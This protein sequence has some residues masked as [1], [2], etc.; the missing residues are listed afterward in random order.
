VNSIAAGV[1]TSD[2]RITHCTFTGNGDDPNHIAHDRSELYIHAEGA[3]IDGNVFTGVRRAAP[4]AGAAIETHG[5]R[6]SITGNVITDYAGG[7]NLTGAAPS[8]S[9]GNVVSGN[10]IRGVL[11]G[12]GIWS[13][14]YSAHSSG[15]GINGLTITGN[16]I[17]VNQSSYTSSAWTATSSSGISVE[18]HS[19]LPLANVNISGNVITFDLESSLRKAS[20]ASIGI[21]WWSIVG[22]TAENLTIENNTI[23]NAPVAGIRLAAALKGCRIKRNIIR[24]AGSSLDKTI[25][26]GYKTP[27]FIAGAPSTDVE[28]TD[29][30][31]I[32]SLEPSRIRSA[33]HLGTAKGTSTGVRLHNKSVLI[34]AADRASFKSHVEISDDNTMPLLTETWD[35]FV[36]PTKRVASGS[37][38]NDSKSGK[39]WGAGVGGSMSRQQ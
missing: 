6:M 37:A 13:N 38:V 1:P 16:T 29:N 4:A 34:H 33:I 36:P 21:G 30:Q 17:V 2:I 19:N 11:S 5:S 7:M 23:E 9:V 8:D 31:I 20:T 32:D 10:T 15:Y 18:P 3:V 35:D 25:A 14:T 12:M 24:N 39:S 27:I 22:Q 26:E 28:I